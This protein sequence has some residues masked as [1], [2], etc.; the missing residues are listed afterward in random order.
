MPHT[1][2]GIGTHYYGARNE[3]SRVG[4]C[5]FCRRDTVLRSYDTRLWF[6]ILFI[7]IIPLGKKRILNYCSACTRHRVLALAE[8]EKIKNQNL[9]EAMAG[10]AANPQDPKAA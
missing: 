3:Q 8:W 2:N 1:V 10:M 6:V 4:I 9:S 5:E 7:P